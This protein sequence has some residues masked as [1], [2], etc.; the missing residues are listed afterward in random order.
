MIGYLTITNASSNVVI[1]TN[2]MGTYQDVGR[3]KFTYATAANTWQARKDIT[4]TG[5]K[6]T[7]DPVRLNGDNGGR[8]LGQAPDGTYYGRQG[9]SSSSILSKPSSNAK[10][11]KAFLIE[12]AFIYS[13]A[14]A[15]VL[16][17][18]PMRLVGPNGGVTYS[19]PMGNRVYTSNISYDY[20]NHV[21]STVTDVTSFVQSQGWGTYQG[22]D[23][24]YWDR[25]WGGQS[26]QN[27][28]WKLI[29]IC[30]DES[31]PIRIVKLNYG[32][33]DAS[34]SYTGHMADITIDGAGIRTKTNGNVTGQILIAGVG[35]D[36]DG[37]GSY[38]K[39]RP[40]INKEFFSLT[41]GR[42]GN[43]NKWYNFFEGMAVT[44]GVIRSDVKPLGYRKSDGVPYHN[45]DFI[46]M[47]VNSTQSNAQ[48]GH[49]AYFVN[50]STE[51]SI[52]AGAQATVNT[53]TAMGMIADIDTATY[54][55]SMSH[56][57]QAWQYVDHQMSA[58]LENNT[59]TNKMSLGASGGYAL[60]NVDSN[61]TLNPQ[62]IKASFYDRS[63]NQ[64]YTLP[65]SM[66]SVNGNTIK[67]IFGIDGNG[68]SQVGDKLDITFTGKPQIVGNYK[69][70]VTMYANGIIKENNTVTAMDTT[71]MTSAENTFYAKYNNPPVIN[72]NN[73]SF[74]EGQYSNQY[75]QDTLRW[76]DVSAS[77][78]EDGNL[79]DKVSI[80]YDNVDVNTPGSYNVIYTVTDSMGKTT[81]KTVTITVLYNNPPVLEAE[82]RWFYVSEDVNDER[83]LE[84]V[85]AND[86]EDG[87]IKDKV[88]II[89]NTVVNHEIG[90]YEV[91]YKVTDAYGKSDQKT[92]KITIVGDDHRDIDGED[93]T[94]KYIRHIS[95][96]YIDTLHPQSVWR[97]NPALRDM[98]TESLFKSGDDQANAIWK[99]SNQEIDQIKALNEADGLG[100]EANKHFLEVF[101]GNKIK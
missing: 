60:I 29:V 50:D 44:N 24:P 63:S 17:D 71:K 96:D 52:S 27:A 92:V 21:A 57:G 46:L 85:T 40:A 66:I 74:Y 10:V 37:Y 13:P 47:D 30:E 80:K 39:F 35:G 72:A 84:R 43:L 94:I 34:A 7:A 41:T 51:I 36:T 99:F 73:Q 98:L 31:L 18:R 5:D 45:T 3:Y 20:T 76:K 64:T 95:K 100:E 86:I 9:N 19:N 42:D 79:S 89:A 78:V 8:Y 14:T 75:W 11:K 26:D 12:E 61:I 62:S 77:D 32:A 55:S 90:V 87:D 93:A 23:I 65:S 56:S 68:Q 91:T 6:H 59:N 54:T 70:T 22:W 83:L 48:N 67:V 49:N 69:N 16:I 28:S 82:D 38:F 15:N 88:K 81:E 53:I 101:G 97:T 25:S 4:G 33:V 2:T 1:R 58:H